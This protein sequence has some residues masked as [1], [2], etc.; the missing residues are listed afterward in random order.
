M[1]FIYKIS[2]NIKIIA[3]CI[4]F[5]YFKV[6]VG[7][8]IADIQNINDKDFT[9]TLNAFFNLRWTDKRIMIDQERFKSL[10]VKGKSLFDKCFREYKNRFRFWSPNWHWHQF[11]NLFQW[12]AGSSIHE[13][14]PIDVRFM[15]ELWSPDAEIRN[16]KEFKILSVLSKVFYQSYGNDAK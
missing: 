11:Y 4:T 16:L 2:T 6:N 8:D 3:I 10:L 15:Q 1:F 14:L 9:V 13:P 12:L 7:I 5:S